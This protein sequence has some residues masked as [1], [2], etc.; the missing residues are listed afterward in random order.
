MSVINLVSETERYLHSNFSIL[1]IC[2]A[3]VNFALPMYDTY[4]RIARLRCCEST[5][6]NNL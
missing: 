4:F 5:R 3:Y 6:G 1:S 2:T